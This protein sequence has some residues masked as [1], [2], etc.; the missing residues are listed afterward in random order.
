MAHAGRWHGW[1]EELEFLISGLSE[2]ESG[3]CASSCLQR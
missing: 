1:R 3:V 2:N